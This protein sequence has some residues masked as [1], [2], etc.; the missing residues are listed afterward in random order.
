M[1]LIMQ[2]ASALRTQDKARLHAPS[3]WSSNI[4]Q[5]SLQLLACKIA[6]TPAA[7]FLCAVVDPRFCFPQ[8]TV[9]TM[10][11]QLGAFRN[12]NFTITDAQGRPFFN[13]Q[14]AS[15]S[16]S[17]SRQL[18]DC[19]NVPI[20]HMQK[21]IPSF[22]GSWLINRASDRVRV[23]TVRP[24]T[25]SFTPCKLRT[26]TAVKWTSDGW[27]RGGQ[28]VGKGVGSTLHSQCVMYLHAHFASPSR[29]RDQSNCT[30]VRPSALLCAE[31]SVTASVIHL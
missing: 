15:L 4:T 22:R 1:L 26:A 7:V 14:A 24:A 13:L 29:R 10:Q 2:A 20:L 18:L 9:L 21:K 31:D 16:F 5:V 17:D 8:Q 11:E 12:D 28:G 25:F 3:N 27:A 23:A 19:Y 30:H 6:F